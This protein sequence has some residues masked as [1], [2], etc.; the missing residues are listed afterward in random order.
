MPNSTEDPF[1]NASHAQEE[2][3]M[4][5]AARRRPSAVRARVLNCRRADTEFGSRVTLSVV[6]LAA[7]GLAACTNSPEQQFAISEPIRMPLTLV[8][9]TPATRI[10]I[11][12]MEVT[13]G[14]DT[15]GGILD[16]GADV[17]RK[18][19][20][21]RLPGFN[22]WTDWSGQEFRSPLFEVP[23]ITIDGR[24]FRNLTAEQTDE[25]APDDGHGV[26]NSFGRDFLSHYFVV[27]DYANSAMTL[28][29][30]GSSATA[31]NQCGSL[32]VPMES[33]K[34]PG[35]VVVRIATPS[36]TYRAILDTGAQYSMMP[37]G[38]AR[39]RNLSLTF[40]G[41]TPFY[42][43]EKL[44]VAEQDFGPLEFVVL[45]AG[46]PRDFQVFL[47]YNFFSKHVVCLDYKHREILVR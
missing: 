18:V 9:S 23:S 17:I 26:S 20:A 44:T 39:D 33:T 14:M 5:P 12:K 36:G 2:P 15:G 35:L 19:G 32:R 27:I 25:P 40:R 30:P 11:G 41:D 16:L 43:M 8:E 34:E 3:F 28:W 42:K 38:L 21:R 31:R 7:I 47:G 4:N 45:P 22:S 24:T 10:M 37:E 13:I 1:I 29:P 46:P 6:A